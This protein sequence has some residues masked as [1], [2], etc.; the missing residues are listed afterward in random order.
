MTIC[1]LIQKFEGVTHTQT[2]Y[3]KPTGLKESRLKVILGNTAQTSGIP[4]E[5]DEIQ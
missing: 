1:Q 3:N 2:Q 5:R 4:E